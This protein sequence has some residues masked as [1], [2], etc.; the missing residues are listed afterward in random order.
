MKDELQQIK[1]MIDRAKAILETQS[2]DLHENFGQREI[3]EIEDRAFSIFSS[4]RQE[5]FRLANEF[6]DW[7]ESQ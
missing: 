2:P 6:R 3:R 4:D 5:A 1:K 7:V